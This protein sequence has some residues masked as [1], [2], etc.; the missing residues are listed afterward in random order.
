M[1][2]FF[3]KKIKTYNNIQSLKRYKIYKFFV[4]SQIYSNKNAFAALKLDGS[5]VTWGLP[6]NGGDSSSVSSSLA[7]G[8]VSIFGTQRYNSISTS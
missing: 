4:Y 8:V 3:Y 5:V 1:I 6:A 2:L 7:S